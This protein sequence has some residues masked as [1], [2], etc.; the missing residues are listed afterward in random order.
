LL[1]LNVPTLYNLWWP[2]HSI[3]AGSPF[4]RIERLRSFLLVLL[5]LDSSQVSSNRLGE[6]EFARC[7][8]SFC[9]KLIC[10]L[11]GRILK[12][13]SLIPAL[14][15]HFGSPTFQRFCNS[16]I[17]VSGREKAERG[18]RYLT[19]IGGLPLWRCRLRQFASD[20]IQHL[21]N[22]YQ[23]VL[24]GSTLYPVAFERIANLSWNQGFRG[25]AE[26]FADAICQAQRFPKKCRLIACNKFH[27]IQNLFQANKFT[28]DVFQFRIK[29][30]FFARNLLLPSKKVIPS[31]FCFFLRFAVVHHNREV[32]LNV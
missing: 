27:P 19:F 16:R 1:S 7:A 32:T 25:F 12:C 14:L 3:H 9:R 4:A 15:A 26:N 21:V 6:L 17:R 28:S 24:R 10:E 29:L 5:L 11:Q 2:S 13:M 23:E 8:S 31:A 22:V 18:K 30:C 20:S